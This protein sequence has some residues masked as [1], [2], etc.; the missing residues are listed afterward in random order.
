MAK[1]VDHHVAYKCDLVVGLSF[2]L[3]IVDGVARRGEQQIRQPIG[4]QAVDFLGHGPIVAAESRFDVGDADRQL[5][6]HEGR[7]SRRVHVTVDDDP[8]GSLVDQDRLDTL[9]DSRGLRR[10]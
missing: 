10:M 9:H 6:R 7:G 3:Q 4:H 8:I 2:S 1:G 5:G